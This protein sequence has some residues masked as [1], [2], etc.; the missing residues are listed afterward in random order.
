MVEQKKRQGLQSMGNGRW[1]D[2][3]GAQGLANA[4]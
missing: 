2:G 4:A 1:P 3:P